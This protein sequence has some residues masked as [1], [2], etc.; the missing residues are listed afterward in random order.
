MTGGSLNVELFVIAIAGLAIP[1]AA[2]TLKMELGSWDVPLVS[3]LESDRHAR[4]FGQL[5][6]HS[7]KNFLIMCMV[8]ARFARLHDFINGMSFGH[9]AWQLPAFPQF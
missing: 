5:L 4:N 9:T 7:P 2:K 8:A 6:H 1:F 3:N